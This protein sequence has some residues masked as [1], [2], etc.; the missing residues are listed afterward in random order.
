MLGF[1]HSGEFQAGTDEAGRGCLAGPVVAAA[2]VLPPDYAH[3]LI[4][5]SKKLS[6]K[7][8]FFLREEIQ[9]NALSFAF[10]VCSPEE[11]DEIN[12]LQASVKAMHRALEGLKHGFDIILADGNYF[13]PFRNV[14]HRCVVGGD[15][16][17]LPIAAASILAKTERDEMMR[18]LSK[19]YPFYLWE[20][21]FG[22]PTKAHREAILRHGIS[23]LHRK[24]FRLLHQEP[25]LF[26]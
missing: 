16:K 12:I 10:G 22:Y 4:N 3:P 24:T 2:V 21:N 20:K 17:Y 1:W 6:E 23:P 25:D 26:A 9:K 13:H 7:E 8:R 5:D 18:K 11:I 14:M 15:A 19:E